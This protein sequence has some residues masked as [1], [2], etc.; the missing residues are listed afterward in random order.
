MAK[1]TM[2]SSKVPKR[3]TA[4]SKARKVSKASGKAMKRKVA[5]PKPKRVAAKKEAPPVATTVETVAVEAI[6][7]PASA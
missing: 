2:Q 1:R 6:E 7:Q 3:K 5:K 4:R